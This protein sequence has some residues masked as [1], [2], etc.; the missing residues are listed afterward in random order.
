MAMK[1]IPILIFTVLLFTA[2]NHSNNRQEKHHHDESVHTYGECLGNDEHDHGRDHGTEVHTDEIAFSKAQAEAAGLEIETAAPGAFRQVIKTSG[3]LLPAQ[4]DEITVVAASS[5]VVSF[6]SSDLSEGAAVKAGQVLVHLSAQNMVDGDPAIKAKIEYEAARAAYER[7]GSLVKENI[8]SK[9][10]FEQAQ[11]RYESARTAYSASSKMVTAKGLDVAAPASGIIKRR[12]VGEGEYVTVGQALMS[13]GKNRRLQLRA[14]VPAQHFK[15]LAQVGD[16][17][18]KVSYDDATHKLS[19]LNGRLLSVGASIDQ[20]APYLPVTVEFDN[21]G[22]FIPGAFAE[23][24]LLAAT[25]HDVM[26]LPLTAITEE[27]GLYFVYLQLDDE[28]YK[29]QE[30]ALGANDG[31]RV[32]ILS[33][34]SA[35]DRVVTRGAYQ[36]KLAA[37]SSVIPEGHSH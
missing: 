12:L 14:D 21:T 32:H 22:A 2:C 29:K 23:I 9:K 26:T 34:V 11:L 27:Q 4:G 10:D 35:G 8:V 33:G 16:A 7:A 17:H 1:N 24:Y 36:V 19:E 25:Q 20:S 31:Q 18:F 30:V 6:A 37:T 5:G 3:Q 13:L 15:A 28:G